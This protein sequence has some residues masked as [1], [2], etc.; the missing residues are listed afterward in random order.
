MS[1][2]SDKAKVTKIAFNSIQIKQKAR[3]VRHGVQE[4]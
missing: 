3:R 2:R 1:R 4:Y